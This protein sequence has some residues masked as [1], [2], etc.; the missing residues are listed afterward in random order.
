MVISDLY[1]ADFIFG[2]LVLTVSIVFS[3]IYRIISSVP[4]L[5][6]S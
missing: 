3:Y 4:L 6:I 5:L 1:R 2:A